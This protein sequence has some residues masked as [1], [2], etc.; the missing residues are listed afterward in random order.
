MAKIV[1]RIRIMTREEEIVN[2]AKE[3]EKKT[4]FVELV[5]SPLSRGVNSAYGIGFIEG[6]VWS[7]AHQR[8]DILEEKTS[9]VRIVI[10]GSCPENLQK[11][12]RKFS[13]EVS[14]G[15]HYMDLEVGFIR[16]YQSALE[17]ACEW[18]ELHMQCGVH[19]QNVASTI[20]QF[21]Q[22]MEE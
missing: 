15:H 3:H 13:E 21:K 1:K 6:C 9:F 4:E 10:S 7:D 17:N 5:K 16:G 19:P 14:N 11:K 2:A 22:A 12:A 20:K 18:L 8:N